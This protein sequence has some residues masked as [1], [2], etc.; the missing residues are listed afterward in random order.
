VEKG[1]DSLLFAQKSDNNAGEKMTEDVLQEWRKDSC[2]FVEGVYVNYSN[3][4][5]YDPYSVKHSIYSDDIRKSNACLEKLIT[6]HSKP[7][8][9][10]YKTAS[11]WTDFLV[12]WNI[13]WITLKCTAFLHTKESFLE[14]CKTLDIPSKDAK[15]IAAQIWNELHRRAI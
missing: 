11:W 7:A 6:A 14:A 2:D 4:D 3:L 8:R 10:L 5:K 1:F 12:W 13:L 9:V 15:S